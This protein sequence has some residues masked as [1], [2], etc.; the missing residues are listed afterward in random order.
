MIYEN[1][2]DTDEYELEY[3]NFFFKLFIPDYWVKIY[4]GKK[5]EALYND[6]R[7]MLNALKKVDKSKYVLDI[8]ANHGLFS[9][10]ASKLGYKVFGFEPVAQNIFSLMLAKQANNL[11][12]FDMFHLALSNK[13]EEVKI[14]VPECPDNSSL[15]QVAA[16]SN[17][18]GKEFKVEKVNAVIFDD[19]I[20]NNPEYKNIGFIKIDVQGS[21][22]II[23]EGM[24]EFLTK[25]KNIYLVVEYEHHLLTMGHTFEQ[26]DNLVTSYGF[27]ILGKLTSNDKIFYKP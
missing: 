23:F 20:E 26:L 25:T 3:D 17:M 18:R 11:K 1:I 8:G 4:K 24:K 10:P 15:S 19:W 22:Y 21:E 12:D 13:N 5:H 6:Y 16:V 14:Y 9:V 27:N 7:L 2:A